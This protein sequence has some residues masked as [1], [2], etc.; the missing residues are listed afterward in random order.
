M[1]ERY[2][3]FST[4]TKTCAFPSSK[5][6]FMLFVTIFTGVVW[7]S[8][9]AAMKYSSITRGLGSPNI[10]LKRRLRYVLRGTMW[11]SWKVSKKWRPITPEILMK[12]RW[13]WQREPPRVDFKML[14]KASYRCMSLFLWSGEVVFISVTSFDPL[15]ASLL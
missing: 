12:L 9:L 13:M 3:S 8:C 2:V 1:V 15:H 11:L 14:W 5:N 4:Q 10:N 7:S 6:T